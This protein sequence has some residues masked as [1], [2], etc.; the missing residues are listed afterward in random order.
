[1]SYTSLSKA[2]L[3][4][5]KNGIEN[6]ISDLHIKVTKLKENLNS[7]KDAI[8]HLEKEKGVAI[9]I[10]SKLLDTTFEN[11]LKPKY[12]WKRKIEKCV[13]LENNPVTCREIFNKLKEENDWPLISDREGMKNISSA[14]TYLVREA[15]IIKIKK[16]NA[17]TFLYGNPFMHFDFTGRP[18]NNIIRTS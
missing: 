5:L 6:S 17:G 12:E 3:I 1:M 7:V 8:E 14:L 15:K 4:K 2:E 10:D 18:K 16:R 13:K 11:V 9:S